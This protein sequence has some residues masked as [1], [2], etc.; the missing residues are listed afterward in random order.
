MK[1]EKFLASAK[2]IDRSI[3]IRE[4]YNLPTLELKSKRE[5]ILRL[6]NTLEDCRLIQTMCMVYLKGFTYDE[7]ATELKKSI[8]TVCRY[9][10]LAML[11]LEK[12]W[13]KFGKK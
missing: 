7:V 3:E 4:F 11:R 5:A 1:I 6:F 12:E 9:H 2:G 13:D 10:K 8:R